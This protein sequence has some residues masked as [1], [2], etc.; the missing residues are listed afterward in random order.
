ML[1]AIN[2]TRRRPFWLLALLA[3]GCLPL[4]SCGGSAAKH[5]AEMGAF[6]LLEMLD[7]DNPRETAKS[8]AEIEI[9]K[10]QVIRADADGEPMMLEFRLFAVTPD[11]QKEK[12]TEEFAQY[13]KRIRDAVIGLIQKTDP[14]QMAEPSL[15]Y[16]RGEIVAALNRVMHGKVVREVVFSDYTFVKG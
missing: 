2:Y 5:P 14:D 1:P 11:A 8:F 15:A 9:G 4:A 3:C 10:F 6:E 13:D 12:L 16:L 7:R